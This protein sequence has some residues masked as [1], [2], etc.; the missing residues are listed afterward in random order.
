MRLLNEVAIDPSYGFHVVE[1]NRSNF[2]SEGNLN[3]GS[4]AELRYCAQPVQRALEEFF[5]QGVVYEGEGRK[6]IDETFLKGFWTPTGFVDNA[7]LKAE[8]I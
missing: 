4:V 7:R 5:R 3:A 2:D 1:G 8:E 6:K